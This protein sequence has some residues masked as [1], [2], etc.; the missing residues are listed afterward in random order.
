MLQ[1][2]LKIFEPKPAANSF[3]RRQFFTFIGMAMPWAAH[4]ANN[5]IVHPKK[6]GYG[7]GKY[8]A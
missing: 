4:S 8:G 2:L 7:T 3:T 1:T 5:R 6:T